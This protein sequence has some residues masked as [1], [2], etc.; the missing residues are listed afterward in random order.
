VAIKCPKC[1]FHQDQGSECGRCGI[2]FDRYRPVEAELRS[3]HHP[4]PTQEFSELS[5]PG[6]LRRTFRIF[7]WSS[8]G[9]FA[10]TFALILVPSPAPEVEASSKTAEVAETKVR[11]FAALLEKG[12]AL[13]LEMNQA[14]LNSWL[15]T[16]L[17]L[18]G[19]KPVAESSP[20]RSALAGV[21]K[22]KTVAMSLGS[23]P[24]AEDAQSTIT[25]VKIELLEDSL[26]TYVAFDFH[27]KE[28]TLV[29]EGRVK[30]QDGYLRFEPISGQLGSLPL[31]TVALENAARKLFEDPKNRE[32]FRLPSQIH[33]VH[34]LRGNLLLIPQ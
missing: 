18:K 24:E 13:P 27:G 7:R 22:V 4:D 21:G 11:K 14:E 1:G 12:Q 10:I 32:H 16:N 8:L 9:M 23:G 20:Q 29:L 33:G 19:S 34:V 26:R 6:L 30:T 3:F 5:S 31:P 2:I 25:D 17:E 15:S 28:L